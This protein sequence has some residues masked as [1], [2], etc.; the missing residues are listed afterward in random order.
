MRVEWKMTLAKM[1]ADFAF[2][3]PL[4]LTVFFGVT[5]LISS[6]GSI[7]KSREKIRHELL[8]TYLTEIQGN[9]HS[10]L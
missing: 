5:T 1:A 3:D 10:L 8:T 7:E 9:I 4:F 2:F 6:G